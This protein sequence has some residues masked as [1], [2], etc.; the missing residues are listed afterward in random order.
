VPIDNGTWVFCNYCSEN[1][2][3]VDSDCGNDLYINRT[4]YDGNFS[5]CCQVTNLTS[6]CS[7]LY[8]PY[9]ETQRIFCGQGEITLQNCTIN[10]KFNIREKEYCLAVIPSNYSDE[11]FKCISYIEYQGEVIQ[12]NPQYK[13]TSGSFIGTAVAEETRNSFDSHN[14]LVNFY[15]TK[16]NLYPAYDYTLGLKCSS[17]QRVL[18]AT[19]PLYIDYDDVEFVFSRTQWFIRNWHYVIAGIIL[20]ILIVG[21]LIWLYGKTLRR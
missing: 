6:D 19:T 11:E 10:P 14:G 1:L 4:W 18:T 2:F 20:F 5:T 9:N 3:Y 13:K 7:I 12:T 15:F 21:L 8:S 17:P 16:K